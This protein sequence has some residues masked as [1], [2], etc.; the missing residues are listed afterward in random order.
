ML[1]FY[2]VLCTLLGCCLLVYTIVTQPGPVH[3]LML[4]LFALSLHSFSHCQGMSPV[5]R[6]STLSLPAP[7]LYLPTPWVPSLPV[8]MDI[9]LHIICMLLGHVYPKLEFHLFG[10]IGSLRCPITVWQHTGPPH[11]PLT[12]IHFLLMHL[13]TP[14]ITGLYIG[15]FHLWDTP[16]IWKVEH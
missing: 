5:C 4:D 13:Q 14:N 3:S 15:V 1:T 12:Y 2:L 11:T 9:I 8:F 7:S 6:L 10:H 16:G